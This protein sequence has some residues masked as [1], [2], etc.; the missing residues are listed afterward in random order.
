MS[1]F[2]G[3]QLE[4]ASPDLRREMVRTFAEA[5]M[6]ADAD[7]VCDAAY[8]ERSDE[9]VNSRNGYRDRPWD[10]RA[11]SIELRVPKPRTGSYF[12]D[13]LLGRPTRAE[14]ALISVVA[15]AY[16][17]GLAR[18]ANSSRLPPLS[19]RTGLPPRAT[20]RAGAAGRATR[21]R[22]CGP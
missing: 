2:L 16:L 15:T 21:V 6:G 4:A 14:Q 11:G 10:T 20:V 12:P 3:K 18:C 17:P 13:W 9:R 19:G 22:S 5:L 1:E 7:N 8:G